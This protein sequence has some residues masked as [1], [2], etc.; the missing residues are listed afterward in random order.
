MQRGKT[1]DSTNSVIKV[2]T[3]QSSDH[4]AILDLLEARDLYLEA[5]KLIEKQIIQKRQELAKSLKKIKKRALKNAQNIA[6]RKLE[7]K[8]KDE[9]KNLYKLY[10]ETL[11]KAHEDCFELCVNIA[12]QVIEVEIPHQHQALRKKIISAISELINVNRCTIRVNPKQLK[13]LES[14]L[15]KDLGTDFLLIADPELAEGDAS[16]ETAHGRT[17]IN[18][19]SHLK[20]L[21]MSLR[22]KLYHFSTLNSK[23]RNTDVCAT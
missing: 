18:W 23:E 7:E 3:L 11:D 20:A 4:A 17:E 8:F 12:R 1:R 13:H 21:E 6:A 10:S 2:G 22:T 14:E 15:P 16:I 9:Y 5:Q 19:I